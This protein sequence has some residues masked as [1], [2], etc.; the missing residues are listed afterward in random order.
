MMETFELSNEISFVSISD[1]PV[2]DYFDF[3]DNDKDLISITDMETITAQ[4][5]PPK[6][7]QVLYII[8]K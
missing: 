6:D 4:S 1:V 5:L 2:K 3:D 7:S 8:K